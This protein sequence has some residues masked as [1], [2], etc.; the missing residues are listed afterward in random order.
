MVFKAGNV[1]RATN[2]TKEDFLAFFQGFP[3]AS[4]VFPAVSDNFPAAAFGGKRR[5]LGE[6]F[7]F[8]FWGR[9]E[10]SCLK[11]KRKKER[12]EQKIL[13]FISLGGIFVIFGSLT[14]A[15]TRALTR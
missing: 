12:L 2:S 7:R 10:E 8:G 3:A 4:D 6:L 5:F 1:F 14:R 9:K 13:A 11:K 15:L